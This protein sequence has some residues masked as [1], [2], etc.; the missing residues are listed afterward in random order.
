[1]LTIFVFNHVLQFQAHILDPYVI[2]IL[3]SN[4]ACCLS[5]LQSTFSLPLTTEYTNLT[6]SLLFYNP[7]N[8]Q[9][10]LYNKALEIMCRAVYDLISPL[11]CPSYICLAS[12]ST[13]F[14]LF[15]AAAVLRCSQFLENNTQVLA[16][17]FVLQ[18]H[19]HEGLSLSPP[20]INPL[21]CATLRLRKLCAYPFICYLARLNSWREEPMS[22]LSS[23][24]ITEGS[25][26]MLNQLSE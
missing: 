6:L 15:H 23:I 7:S 12:P 24:C 16:C 1:M 4:Q 14:P 25:Q 5:S 2:T 22:Y 11:I 10:F 20:L 21:S 17:M 18:F 8:V 19:L 26:Q 9:Q 3:Y 13:S